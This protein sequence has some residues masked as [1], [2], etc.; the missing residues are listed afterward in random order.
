MPIYVDSLRVNG[1]DSLTCHLIADSSD[2]LTSFLDLIG[3][4]LDRR[5]HPSSPWE[6]VDIDSDEREAAVI[7]GAMEVEESE[8]MNMIEERK[9]V[10]ARGKRRGKRPMRVNVEEMNAILSLRGDV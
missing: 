7:C 10:A 6:H 8:V 4:P 3:I 5:E 2:E 1:S 9:K